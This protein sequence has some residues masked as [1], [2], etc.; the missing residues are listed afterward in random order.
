VLAFDA[1]FAITDS[2]VGKGFSD[3]VQALFVV[4]LWI[5]AFVTIQETQ[6]ADVT[7]LQGIKRVHLENRLK[8]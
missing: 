6:R 2:L 3:A 7:G 5:G 8:A 4:A 1:H